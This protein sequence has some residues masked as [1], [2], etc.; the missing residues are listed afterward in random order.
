M[1]NSEPLKKTWL[2]KI[3]VNVEKIKFFITVVLVIMALTVTNIFGVHYLGWET[4]PFLI[5]TGILSFFLYSGPDKKWLPRIVPLLVFIGSLLSCYYVFP[6]KFDHWASATILIM[7][8]S[9]GSL[10]FWAGV[11]IGFVMSMPF[12]NVKEEEQI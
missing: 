6:L 12:R 2:K 1:E 7:F 3:K 8:Y 10:V 11:L 4:L 9:F 5:F